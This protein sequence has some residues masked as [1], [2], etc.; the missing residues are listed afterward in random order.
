MNDAQ[1]LSVFVRV[2]PL[3]ASE[4]STEEDSRVV[5]VLEDTMVVFDPKDPNDAKQ[6]RYDHGSRRNKEMRYQFD[7]VFDSDATQQEVFELTAAPLI[8]SVING[9]N[10]TIFAYGATGCGKTFTITGAPKSPGLIPR[11]IEALFKR[12]ASLE[13]NSQWDLALSYLEVYNETIRDLLVDTPTSLELREDGNRVVVAGL[14]Q[15]KSLESTQV[16]AMLLRGNANRTQAPT[17]AN[18]ESSRSHAVLQVHLTNKDRLPSGLA[19]VKTSCLSIIDLAGSE[20]ASVTRN[21]GCRLI[22]GANI[23]RSLL[24]LGNC[25]NALAADKS[26]HVPYR[27]S[28]LTR[29][30]KFSLSGSCKV[31]MIANIS[32]ALTHYEETHNTLKYA[33]RAKNIKTKTLQNTFSVAAR[34][35]EY[36]KI[37]D[38]LRAEI[39]LLRQSQLKEEQ[40]DDALK[41]NTDIAEHLLIN[42]QSVEQ[43][44]LINESKVARND[45]LINL[46]KTFITHVSTIS[47]LHPKR[48]ELVADHI[49]ALSCANAAFVHNCD[50]T[51]LAVDHIKAQLQ[52]LQIDT[53][54]IL[55]STQHQTLCLAIKVTLV[56]IKSNLL[57]Q[58]R[59]LDD[60]TNSIVSDWS[61][62]L[63]GWLNSTLSVLSDGSNA[64]VDASFD[65]FLEKSFPSRSGSLTE[66]EANITIIDYESCIE[67]TEL[68]KVLLKNSSIP[69]ASVETPRQLKRTRRIS[70]DGDTQN[71]PDNEQQDNDLTPVPKSSKKRRHNV[72]ASPTAAPISARK[73]AGTP[74]R[75]QQQR[76]RPRQSL[77]P[78]PSFSRNGDSTLTKSFDTQR[79]LRSR[80]KPQQ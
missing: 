80:S 33:N 59:T 29:L 46:F 52:R 63:L 21:S 25:I 79:V 5:T 17:E 13:T 35:G 62:Q 70:D 51:R 58:K 69:P 47:N 2:R 66:E 10:A 41:Q 74:R 3:L 37:I 71:K 68:P 76:R 55:N 61:L 36:P 43:T 20:R 11:T 44:H 39:D 23:N 9:F 27:D 16:M 12:I 1:A 50:E 4:R 45:K 67:E 57:D 22:E 78:V 49:D 8:E 18:A 54:Q 6:R 53:K 31:V 32:P 38:A 26:T 30:L 15:H 60:E 48:L 42:L 14:S 75:Q 56:D 28:K 77:I 34:I 24:A 7:R 73:I 64:L 19:T 65:A 40:N 72:E